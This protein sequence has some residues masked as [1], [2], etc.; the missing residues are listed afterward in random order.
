MQKKCLKCGHVNP[1]ARG[2]EL[3]AC[4]SCGAIYSRVEAALAATGHVRAAPAPAPT[5]PPAAAAP[6]STPPRPPPSASLADDTPYIETLRA[7]SNYPTFRQVVGLFAFVGYALAA[8]FVIVTIIG[9]VRS[10]V[11]MVVGGIFMAIL[12][13]VITRVGQELSLMMADAADAVVRAAKQL[14]R[15]T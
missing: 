12:L 15:S 8:I 2:G 13:V 14:E 7:T 10:Q 4:P 9:M 11:A 1:Q 5:A 6:A 3:E